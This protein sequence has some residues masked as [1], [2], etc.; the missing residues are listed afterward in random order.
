MRYSPLGAVVVVWALLSWGLAAGPGSA[1]VLPNHIYGGT[2]DNDADLSK[3]KLQAQVDALS[4]LPARPM[5]RIV[6]DRGTNVSDYALSYP[7]IRQVSSTMAELGDSSEVKG[8]SDS[9]Y[10][11]WV[12]SMVTAYAKSTDSGRWAMKSTANGSGHRRPR[13][14]V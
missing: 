14:R 4:H 9:S 11:T 3:S 10:G 5:V 13:W 12:Q 1:Q 6:L 2:L 8:W 7:A